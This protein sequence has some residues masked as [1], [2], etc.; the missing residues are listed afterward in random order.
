[1]ILH[2]RLPGQDELEACVELQ[3]ETWGYDPAT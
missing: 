3:V 1:M 2:S